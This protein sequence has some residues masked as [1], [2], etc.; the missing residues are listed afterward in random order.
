MLMK[1]HH[2]IPTTFYQNI[3]NIWESKL[4]NCLKKQRSSTNSEL[5]FLIF[6]LNLLVQLGKDFTFLS[7]FNPVITA[8]SGEVR[9]IVQI[10]D[11]ILQLHNS[12]TDLE[13]L[14]TEWNLLLI[15]KKLKKKKKTSNLTDFQI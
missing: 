9:S 12:I 8:V 1:F 3:K 15:M 6:I 10:I 11:F 13:A 5:T 2:Q 4:K 14:N 7:T